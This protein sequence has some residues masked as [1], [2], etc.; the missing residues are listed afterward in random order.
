M[1]IF[2]SEQIKSLDALT[3][4]S[5]PVS[6]VDLMERAASELSKWYMETFDRSHRVLIF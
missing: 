5:E 1:K 3:I 2:L 6:S 4:I